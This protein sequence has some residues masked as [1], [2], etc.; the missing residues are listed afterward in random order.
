MKRQTTK[1]LL[2]DSFRKLAEKKPVNKITVGEIT[3]GCG[4]SPAT[5]YRHFRDKYYLI[6]WDYVRQTEP[7]MAK[8]GVGEYQW[9]ETWSD[10]LRLF[11]DNRE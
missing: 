11:R 7:I 8:V 10:G 9:K 4:L 6:V 3:G 1:E 2:A 5:F